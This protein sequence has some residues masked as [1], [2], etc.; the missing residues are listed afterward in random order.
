MGSVSEW[1][2][3][4]GSSISL[5][6]NGI[7]IKVRTAHPDDSNY[8][9]GTYSNHRDVKNLNVVHCNPPDNTASSS[10]YGFYQC[11]FYWNGS[12]DGANFCVEKDDSAFAKGSTFG[13]T[14][15]IQVGDVDASGFKD[16]PTWLFDY[17]VPSS[18]SAFTVESN[19]GQTTYSRYFTCEGAEGRKGRIF[20]TCQGY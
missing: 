18:D 12:K 3:A 10:T 19:T 17:T 2:V 6:P 1:R 8:G 15:A 14:Y 4:A 13:L 11:E 5:V 20:L 7:P 16:S 9:Q